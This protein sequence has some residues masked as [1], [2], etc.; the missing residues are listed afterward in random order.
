MRGIPCSGSQTSTWRT[1]QDTWGPRSCISNQFSGDLSQLILRPH[2]GNSGLL[3]L[4]LG[5]LVGAALGCRDS[6]C[7]L[8]LFPL[9]GCHLV[10]G[11]Y[12]PCVPGQAA[13]RQPGFHIIC[14]QMA[15]GSQGHCRSSP[16]HTR[17]RLLPLT[18]RSRKTSF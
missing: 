16:E 5:L 18:P 1:G 3:T 13:R 10:R 11:P 15:F 9:W 7:P 8:H 6:G 12:P 2:Q 4:P 14:S 17:V